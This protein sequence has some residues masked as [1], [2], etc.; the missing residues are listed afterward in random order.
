MHIRKIIITLCFLLLLPQLSSAMIKDEYLGDVGVSV[1]GNERSKPQ[2]IESLVRKCLEKSE[3]KSWDAVDAGSLKQCITNSRLFR[4]VAVEVKQPEIHVLAKDRWT[5]IPIPNAYS[6]NG[7]RSVGVLVFDSNLL[8][9][10]KTLGAGGAVS[11]NGNTVSLFYFD[12][13]VNFSDFTF[14]ISAL[15][16]SLEYDAYDHTTIIYGFNKVEEGFRLSPG[17]KITPSLEILLPL[18]YADKRY[19]TLDQFATPADYRAWNTGVTISYTDTDYKL[20]YNDGLSGQIAWSTQTERS[21]NGKRISNTTARIEWNVLVFKKHA[22]QLALNAAHQ[23]DATAGD[24]SMFGR[25]LGYR[26]IQPNGLWTREIVTGSVD[27]QIPLAKMNHGTVTVAPFAD[28]GRYKPF[29]SGRENNYAA[30]GIGAYY[31]I[32]LVNFPG[33]GLQAG[34]NDH[35]MGPFVAFQIGLAIGPR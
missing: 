26:G 12:P 19:S 2:L 31:F 35:F 29:F 4:E 6:S 20:F 9:Y 17:Y 3:F 32:N 15:R 8:G 21:D 34:V 13:S 11:T 14:R 18:S 24:V 23:S 1:E 27:Y 16:S 7:K 5:L 22:L 10:G 30:Y 28:Y 25:T 33:I